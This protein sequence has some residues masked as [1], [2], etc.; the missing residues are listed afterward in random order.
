MWSNH[1]VFT[2]LYKESIEHHT[3]TFDEHWQNQLLDK[4]QQSL[5]IFKTDCPFEPKTLEIVEEKGYKRISMEI[6]TFQ[7]LRMQFYLLIPENK[8]RQP[9]PLVLAIHGHGYGNK[10]L[11]GLNADGT[12][13]VGI[14]GIHKDFAI[15]LVNKGFIVAAPELI[16][17]GERRYNTDSNPENEGDNTCYS[18]ASQLLLFG[19][20]LAGLRVF[21]CKRLLD[22]LV[23]EENVDENKIGCMGISGGG[24]VTAFLSATDKRIQ[25][26]VISGYTNQFYSSIMRRHHCLDNYIPGILQYAEMPEIIALSVPR[27]LF[28][29]AGIHDHLFPIKATRE[30]VKKIK[31]IY[32]CFGVGDAVDYQYFNGGHEVN[33][34]KSIT[35]LYHLLFNK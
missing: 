15:S 10:D 28:I 34:D 9:L 4:F 31:K 7:N 25:A 19:K 26:A 32:S 30:A 27:P 6:S 18:F 2:T 13:R 33:G 12:K 20:T 5:G 14:Q 16:G 1:S 29:E 21:E 22:Y 24:L 11:V 35:W 8:Q 17:F 3:K 23:T